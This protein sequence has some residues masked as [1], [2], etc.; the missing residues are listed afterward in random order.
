[1]HAGRANDRNVAGTFAVPEAVARALVSWDHT[2]QYAMPTDWLYSNTKAFTK[3]FD[4]G[5][6]YAYL[7]DHTVEG[8]VILPVGGRQRRRR[9]TR[10]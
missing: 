7:L 4:L 3:T 10:S 5:K 9:I 1:M 8:R 2:T 6:Q